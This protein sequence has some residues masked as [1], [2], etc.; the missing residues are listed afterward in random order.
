MKPLNSRVCA[1][2]AFLCAIA[3]GCR[4]ADTTR[5]QVAPIDN[6]ARP[7]ASD[8][9]PFPADTTHAP[10]S[11]SEPLTPEQLKQGLIARGYDPSKYTAV[12]GADGSITV[13]PVIATQPIQHNMVHVDQAVTLPPNL[14]YMIN[15]ENGFGV[16][17][18]TWFS[19]DEPKP[20]GSGYKFTDILTGYEQVVTG[21]ITISKIQ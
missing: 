21:D 1:V 12:E 15:R 2:L 10:K 9:I 20:Y 7:A 14:H 5:A 4:P 8:S 3:P 18:D 19:K 17:Q 13:Y 6:Q 11:R 16:P